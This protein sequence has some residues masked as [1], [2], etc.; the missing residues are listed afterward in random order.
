MEFV[1]DKYVYDNERQGLGLF[2][3]CGEHKFIHIIEFPNAIDM[4]SLTENEKEALDRAFFYIHLAE[5]IN[6]YKAF[7]TEEVKHPILTKHEADFFNLFYSNGLGELSYRNN[8]ELPKDIFKA[9]EEATRVLIPYEV[10]NNTTILVGGGKD[11]IT[12]IEMLGE[13][14]SK[15]LSVITGQDKKVPVAIEDTFSISEKEKI[16]VYRHLSPNLFDLKDVYNGHVPITGNIAFINIACSMLY[17]F[18]NIVLS[19]ERSANCG[20]IEWHGKDIN[21]QWSK[22]FEFEKMFDE[23]IKANINPE[24]NYFSLLRPLSE[25]HIAKIFSNFTKYHQNF[26]SCNK[27]FKINDRENKWCCECDK[28]RFVFLMLAPFMDDL[29]EIFGK[30][31]LADENNIEG[32]TALIGLTEHKPFDCVGEYEESIVALRMLQN[33]SY[34]YSLIVVEMNKLIDDMNINVE[35]LMKQQFTPSNEHII[36]AEF[37]TEFIKWI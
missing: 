16:L 24:L 15:L 1:F 34:K 31:L 7:L 20:N 13:I 33:S 21:H 6:Y 12:S 5:G 19:N 11:S 37:F 18:N 23:F 22:S 36:P 2:Y 17:G 9:D 4:E 35:E 8:K 14:D 32:Y 3:S 28:C 30:N 10:Q 25:I 27:T 29:P 26:I